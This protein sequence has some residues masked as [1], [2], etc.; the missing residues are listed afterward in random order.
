MPYR[1][2]EDLSFCE[3]D[4]QVVFLDT[5]H[6]RYFQL[7]ES[8]K[9]AFRA[10][11]DDGDGKGAA[12]GPLVGQNILVETP[13]VQHQRPSFPHIRPHRS[14]LE[15]HPAA[16]KMEMWVLLEVLATVHATW[17]HLR[18]RRFKTI[19]DDV[20]AYRTRSADPNTTCSH[21]ST[22]PEII[23]AATQFN[24]ARRYVPIET[25]CLLDSL[26][27]L[28]FLSRRR[29]WANIVFGVALNPFS[30]HCWVQADDVALNETVSDA[31]VYTPIRVI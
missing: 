3:V 10:F 25:S 14:A 20:V 16:S 4:G 6:D 17:R 13:I 11:L 27:L 19:L 15:Q 1:L 26:S 29:L 28:S 9:H 12:I 2:R 31:N 8:M 24:S 23:K 7:P 5:A 22:E 21:P 18:K 30:A